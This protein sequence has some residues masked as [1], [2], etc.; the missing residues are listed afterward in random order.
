M[1]L[2]LL[3][4]CIADDCHTIRDR[5]LGCSF[6]CS[7]VVWALLGSAL[8]VHLQFA[9]APGHFH[10]HPKPSMDTY[11]LPVRSCVK[12]T[13]PHVGF[14]FNHWDESRKMSYTASAFQIFRTE[15]TI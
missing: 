6:S 11:T 5:R 8:I 12:H 10:S 1:C 15:S 4:Y 9:A 14:L 3:V 13:S 7:S 2:Y